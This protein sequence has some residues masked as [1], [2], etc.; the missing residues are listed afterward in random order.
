MV[1]DN[2]KI[3]LDLLIIVNFFYDF[4]ILSSTSTLLKRNAALKRVL[5]S[6]F[7]GLFSMIS[8]FIKF[9]KIVLLVLKILLSILM[10]YV[11][12]GKEKFLENLFYFYIITI[13]LGG[14]SYLFGGDDGYTSLIL[15]MIVSPFI[16]GLYI[17]AIREYKYK[18]SMIHDVVII[19]GTNTY[20]FSGYLDTGNKV[21]DPVTK[22]PVIMVRKDIGIN[23]DKFMYV[24]ITVVNSTSLLKCIKVDKVIID[25]K[26]V[27]V[28]LGLSDQPIFKDGID[29][30]LNDSL[31]EMIL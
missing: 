27:K 10:V 2:M 23:Q 24:P 7:L 21:I 30:I 19:D 1:G 25:N 28:L 4:L 8:L 5:F 11:A 17:K 16:I 9:D 31:R 22:L 18:I 20:K 29:V 26:I 14:T 3:Y 6:S 12:F 15:L 13:V